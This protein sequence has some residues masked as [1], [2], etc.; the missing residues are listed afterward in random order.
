M[1]FPIWLALTTVLGGQDA[2]AAQAP[3]KQAESLVAL[4]AAIERGAKWLRVRQG[5]DG[6]FQPAVR[7]EVCPVALT[8]MALWSLRFDGAHG[9]EDEAAIRSVRYLLAHRQSNGGI[10]DPQRGLA[11]YTTGVS[12]RALAALGARDDL[13]ELAPALRDA[14]LFAYQ[15]GVPESIVDVDGKPATNATQ[16]AELARGLLKTESN[17]S[18]EKRR[19][20]EFLSHCNS[21][22]TRP[23]LRSRAPGWAQPGAAI[24]SFAYEDLLPY[25]YLD[26]APDHQIAIR[27]LASLKASFTVDV[28]PDLTK[29]Y[30]PG[31]FQVGTQGLYY[32]YLIAAK[33]LAVHRLKSLQMS[34]GTQRE[35]VR[36]LI[37]KLIRL[38]QPDGSWM[39]TDARWWEDEPVLVTCYALIALE[40]CRSILTAR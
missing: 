37:Q 36:E 10:Y 18:A 3:A 25:V 28:N 30:G 21:D 23:A 12:T 4:D 24:D 35:C 29:R 38:Q 20:L 1:L 13:P 5:A 33:T 34:D 26:V 6:A 7:K 2:P 27:A 39:N 31:G 16:A 22:A 15:K 8:A 14:N 40:S 9:F 19:A 17:A 11:V 32:Y